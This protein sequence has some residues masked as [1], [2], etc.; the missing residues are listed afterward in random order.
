MA[1]HNSTLN[2]SVT[3]FAPGG[4]QAGF[5]GVCLVADSQSLG[6]SSLVGNK[7]AAYGTSAAANAGAAA[8]DISEAP[9][10]RQKAGLDTGRNNPY[11]ANYH[12]RI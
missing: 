1:T 5:G 9:S 8:G 6:G 10:T 4:S 2:I 12:S 11:V 3:V 7:V